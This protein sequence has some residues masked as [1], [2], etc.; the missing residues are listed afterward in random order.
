MKTNCIGTQQRCQKYVVAKGA[1]GGYFCG[2]ERWAVGG[3]AGGSSR[4]DSGGLRVGDKKS[5]VVNLCCGVY[6][7]GG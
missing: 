3:G 5:D 7:T 1:V 6:L 2:G 4:N